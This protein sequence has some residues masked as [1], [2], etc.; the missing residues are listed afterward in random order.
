M[1]RSGFSERMAKLIPNVHSQNFFASLTALSKFD[2]RD[3]LRLLSLQDLHK[4]ATLYGYYQ[5]DRKSW[6]GP[7]DVI[8]RLWAI[9]DKRNKA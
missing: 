5:D 1:K 9:Q 4:V 3:T 2:Y 7:K 8:N 6:G